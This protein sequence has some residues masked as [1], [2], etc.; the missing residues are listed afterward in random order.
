MRRQGAKWLSDVF[1]PGTAATNG[2]LTRED[3]NDGFR[4]ILGRLPESEAV[5]DQHM[6]LRSVADLRS[7][8]LRSAEFT[9]TNKFLRFDEKWVLAPVYANTFEMWL[10]LHDQFVSF[11][12]IGESSAPHSTPPVYQAT[13]NGQMNEL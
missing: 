7:A 6:L 13:I 11:G 9:L 12:C 4:W 3:V 2:Q 1:S 8:L 5:V 10:D